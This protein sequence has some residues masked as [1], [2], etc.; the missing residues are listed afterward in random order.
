[1]SET[2]LYTIFLGTSLKNYEDIQKEVEK[3]IYNILKNCDNKFSTVG[4]I[5]LHSGKSMYHGKYA[6]IESAV[7]IYLIFNPKTNIN[8]QDLYAKQFILNLKKEFNQEVVLCFSNK[9]NNLSL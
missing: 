7:T 5:Q 2:N 6:N 8:L 4:T 1:M 9:C 3:K